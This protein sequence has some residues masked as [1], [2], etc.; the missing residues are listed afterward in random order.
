MWCPCV[1]VDPAQ[2]ARHAVHLGV[3]AGEQRRQGHVGAESVL[4][5]VFGHRHP[6]QTPDVLTPADD[7]TN[8]SFGRCDVDRTGVVG[9]LDRIAHFARQQQAVVEIRR[10]ERVGEVP[11]RT[12]HRVFV[13]AEDRQVVVDEVTQPAQCSFS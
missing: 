6:V 5:A 13:R 10:Q 7:L 12:E 9:G 4:V 11:V 3:A 1:V 2:G 8:E